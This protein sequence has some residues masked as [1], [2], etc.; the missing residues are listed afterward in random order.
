MS[1]QKPVDIFAAMDKAGKII[2]EGPWGEWWVKCPHCHYGW[3]EMNPGY[4]PNRCPKCGK[5][6]KI[7]E[8]LIHGIGVRHD[9]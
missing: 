5:P 3:T 6:F 8:D 9:E 1:F 7:R 4:Q 2:T